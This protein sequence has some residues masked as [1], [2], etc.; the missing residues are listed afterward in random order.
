MSTSNK[1][2]TANEARWCRDLS[3][4]NSAIDEPKVGSSSTAQWQ[5]ST[6]KTATKNA[7]MVGSTQISATPMLSAVAAAPLSDIDTMILND[8]ESGGAIGGSY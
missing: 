6:N 3:D 2:T 4:T 5:T 8:S 7:T 1:S